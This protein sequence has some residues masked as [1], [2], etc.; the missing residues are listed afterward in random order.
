MIQQVSN[1]NIPII[2]HEDQLKQALWFARDHPTPV[3]VYT[4]P[5]KIPREAGKAAD[6]GRIHPYAITFPAAKDHVR[7]NLRGEQST[8]LGK[9]EDV[10]INQGKITALQ[11]SLHYPAMEG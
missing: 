9:I 8:S 5:A 2:C 10:E 7:N 1:K 4:F 11:N 3:Q 6:D